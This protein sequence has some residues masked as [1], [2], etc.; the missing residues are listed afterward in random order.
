MLDAM[1][2][3]LFNPQHVQRRFDRAASNFDDADFVHRTTFAG[4]AERLAPMAVQPKTIV[5]LGSATGSGSR[6]LS[7]MYRGARVVSM[8]TSLPMLHEGRSK[9]SWLGKVSAV[10]A[11]ALQIPLRDGS[12]DL[13]VANL[14]LPWLDDLPSCC[15]EI[16]RVLRKDGLFTFATLGPDS[17]EEIRAAWELQDDTPH[18]FGFPDMHDL[19]DLLV[20][21]G[22]R[23]PVLDVDHLAVTYRDTASLYRDLT[24]AGARNTLSARRKSLTGKHRFRQMEDA[25]LGNADD[26]A[27]TL[28]LELVYAH[29]WGGGP[30][31]PPGEYRLDPAA[32]GRRDRSAR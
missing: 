6:E 17:L 22:L 9:R 10:Q 20:R 18:V 3:S 27:L 25:L 31:M 12:A 19:G 23:D 1:S 24:R 28:G 15:K 30:A 32:I 7:R 13:I 8:D 29:A 26:G 5:D 16:S 14:V 4:I 21:S 2:H 11:N